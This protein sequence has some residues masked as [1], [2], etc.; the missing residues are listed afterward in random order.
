MTELLEYFSEQYENDQ[1]DPVK[2]MIHYDVD[3]KNHANTHPISSLY[4]DMVEKK[5]E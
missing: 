4:M 2:N 1:I 3:N 5:Y